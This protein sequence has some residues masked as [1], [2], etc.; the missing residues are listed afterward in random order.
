MNEIK[1]PLKKKLFMFIS[2][3][4]ICIILIYIILNNFILYDYYI[5]DK[6]EQLIDNYKKINRHYKSEADVENEELLKELEGLFENKNINI[7]IIN[8]SRKSYIQFRKSI[9]T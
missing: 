2:G 3:T 8:N 9:R 1:R 7:T 5:G 4:I 6:K